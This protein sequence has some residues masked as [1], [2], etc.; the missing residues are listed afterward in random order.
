MRGPAPGDTRMRLAANGFR[1]PFIRLVL[2][3]LLPA[4]A[5]AAQARSSMEVSVQ[6]VRGDYSTAAATLIETTGNRGS[7]SPGINSDAECKA[8][9]NKVIADGVW[10]T[11]SWDP[12]SHVYL[13][14]VQY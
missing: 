7:A 14:T 13:V 2:V 11:C 8:I 4:A 12:G 6:V 10:A 9:G 1:L 5:L 3:A